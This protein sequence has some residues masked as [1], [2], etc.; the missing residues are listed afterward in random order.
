[1]PALQGRAGCV[2]RC[3]ANTASCPGAAEGDG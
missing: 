3:G 1:L 2:A